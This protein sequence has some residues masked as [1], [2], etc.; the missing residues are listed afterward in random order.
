MSVAKAALEIDQV[1][2][3]YDGHFVLRDL[4][5]TIF[6]GEFVALLGPSGSGK[7]T[8]LR[9]IMREVPLASGAI[10]GP[11]RIAFAPQRAPLLPWLTVLE[12]VEL[13]K[14]LTTPTT[15]FR[16]HAV[17]VLTRA[18]L[19]D[20]LELKSHKLSGGMR[21]RASLVR[22]FLM[23]DTSS[24]SANDEAPVILLDEPFIGLDV[25]KRDL[26]HEL[27]HELWAETKPATIFV[28]HDL[29]EATKLANR[30]VVLSKEGTEF[31]ID[32]KADRNSET[33]KTTSSSWSNEPGLQQEIYEAL[34]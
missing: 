14:P 26:L 20:H 5:L 30:V 28:T 1:S 4:S 9:A 25:V 22:A 29:Q 10:R 8:L 18:G 34:R 31:S 24:R 15:E 17:Q 13:A 7:S 3:E 12:N 23:L 27:T 16:E 33:S 19:G 21:S 11:R 6:T 2:V 32:H